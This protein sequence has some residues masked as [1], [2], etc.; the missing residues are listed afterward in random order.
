MENRMALSSKIENFSI[1]LLGAFL[2]L[3]PIAIIGITTDAYVVPKQ[4][5]LSVVTLVGVVLL[6]VKGLAGQSVRLR[7]TPFD[8]PLALFGLAALLSSI[9]AVNRFDSLISL[10][11]FIFAIL[12]FF[13]ITNSV[14][15]EKD[16]MFLTG[17]LILGAIIVSVIT[18]LSYVKIYPLPFA[19]AK[20]QTFTPLG[21][22]FDQAIYLLVI[23]SMSLTMAWPALKR[24]V[25]EKNRA[26]Y[27]V[28]S[29]ALLVGLAITIIGV[30]TLQKPT[31]LPY[32]IG[33]QTAFAAIS[34]DSGRV[35]QG[36]LMGSGLGTYLVDFTR[37]KPATINVS[38]TLWSLS[39]LRS[40]SFALELIATTGLLGI[41][42]FLFLA[43]RIF[44]SRPFYAPLILLV[45]FAL[46]L[47]FSF[48]S[49]VLL[50]VVLGLYSAH[51]G[52]S[53]RQKHKF[54]DVELKLV[55]LKKG[56]F[57]LTD[58]GVRRDS[59]HEN[60]LPIG[61]FLITVIFSGLIGFVTVKFLYSDYLFQQSFVAAAANDAQKTY[62]LQTRAINMFP[63]R[64]GFHR[65]F[66]Q[67]NLTLA[68]NL[69][70]S[71]PQG[72]TPSQD[73]SNTIYQLI[74]QSINSGR[75]ATTVSPQTSVNWQN[76]SSIYRSLIGFGQNADQFA[77][78]ANQ[79]AITLDPNN[80]QG[81]INYGGIF[82]QLGQWDEAIRQFQIAVSLKP[83]YPNAY[84]NLGHAY[85]QKGDLQTA[86]AQYQ[87][88]RNLVSKDQQSL[89]VINNEIKA[90][91][92]K[93]KSTPVAQGQ[94]AN[95]G[96]SQP[97]TQLPEQNPKVKIPAPKPSASPTPSPK[98][99]PEP[100]ANR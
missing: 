18:L 2:F 92:D 40:S 15:R 7:R 95:L 99:S 22:L 20:N 88:V 61:I 55:A 23:L 48:S 50:F 6:G 31:I 29:I 76:L 81:Y 25:V 73:V 63:Q 46:I 38:E 47:P 91:E 30:I 3:F 75:N 44:R 94:D 27:V 69:A 1:F 43:Y 35:I 16:I 85:E 49:L 28:G 70:S 84:Y 10:V 83:D 26:I 86:L 72:Q 80:P 68:N 24:R 60:L 74:Q 66:S 100:T 82:Y 32:Q 4:A 42:S 54:F 8:L 62:Q 5:L 78:Y 36:F 98:A 17:A 64:D 59:D 37:F 96:I 58:P 45:V 13:I 14:K 90:L 65:I 34:Q 97:Q 87:T 19:F 12:L 77:V 56:V 21:S 9:F 89:N 51:Q 57:A 39:F 93:I 79:Q 53:D 11:P 33:F 52:L 67:I 71:I 41:L